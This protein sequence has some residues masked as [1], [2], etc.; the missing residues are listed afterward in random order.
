MPR[1]RK[2]QSARNANSSGATGHLIGMSTRF[3]TS[4]PPVEVLERA[5]QRGR[6][7]RL[8]EGE[9]ALVPAGAGQALGLLGLQPRAGRDHEH[10]VAAAPCPSS[11]TTSS[12]SSAPPRPP[13]RGR[14]CRR[15]SCRRAAAHDLVDVGEPERDEEQPGLVDVAVVA[16]DD[17]D[18]GLVGGRSAGGG[19]WRSSSR[20]CRR[21][22]SRSAFAPWR[23]GRRRR[24]RRPSVRSRKRLR[25]TTPKLAAWS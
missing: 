15:R 1:S 6:A 13:A 17:V 4:R 11:S 3:T 20:R 22:G 23:K 10:V 5:V 25:G 8:V 21:R 2:Y 24:P 16:V 14:R 9:D 18:L 12:R 7:L 19:G